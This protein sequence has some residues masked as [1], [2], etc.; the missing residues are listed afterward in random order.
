MGVVYL[1]QQHEPIRR[2]VAL[3]IIKPG[4]GRSY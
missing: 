2:K 1:A 4:N 3:K